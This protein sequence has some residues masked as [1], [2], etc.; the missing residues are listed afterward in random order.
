MAALER[1]PQG[2]PRWLQDL[3]DARRGALCRARVSDRPRRGMALHER[4]R[5]SPRSTSLPG[6]PCP[7]TAE[8][9]GGFAYADAPMRLVV[10]NGR[11]ASTLSRDDGS[12]RRRAGRVAGGGDERSRRHRR[13]AISASSPTSAAAASPRSTRPSCR[14]ARSPRARRRGRRD[15]DAHPVR[16]GRRRGDGHEPSA[17]AA[18]GRRRD[19]QV[20][21][22]ESYVGV[23]GR[24]Y[25]A[26]A[27]TEMFVGENAVVDHYQGPAG[28]DRGVPHREPA[29]RIPRAA[30]R[31]RRTRSR[32]AA[33]SFATTH[34]PSSTAKAA[35]ARSTASIWPTA[36]G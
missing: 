36:T 4:R 12:A 35:T 17:H 7:G 28:V 8:H 14:T 5:R 22:V 15:A 20:R 21:L 31:S 27:V 2:G 11:F 10:V 18:R 32:W 6:D 24:T 16:V 3:R 9:A 25:F 13:S 26:N 19:S 1:R 30:R 34:S 29:R 23:P 33:S